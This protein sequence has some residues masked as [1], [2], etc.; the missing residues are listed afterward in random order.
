MQKKLK[1]YYKSTLKKYK[2][3]IAIPQRVFLVLAAGFGL[4]FVFL[5]PPFQEPDAPTHFLRAYQISDF[6]FVAEKFNDEKGGV[7]YGAP[8]PKS[9]VTATNELTGNIP[10]A[11]ANTFNKSLFKKYIAQPLN[12]DDTQMTVI[13]AAGVYSP[14][15]YIPQSIGIN[16][17][18]A[19]N[20]SPL[21]LVW[22]ARL[23]NLVLWIGVIYCAIRL[24][25]FAKWALVVF[26][27]SPIAVFFSA[28]LSPDVTNISLAFLFFSLIVSTLVTG[29]KV[30]GRKL[31]VILLVLFILALSKPVNLMFAFMLLLVPIR[32][33]GKTWKY[34]LYCGAGIVVSLALF[35]V[36]N[37]QVRELLEFQ[38]QIQSGGKNSVSGQLAYILHE[39]LTYIKDILR[40]YVIVANG[41]SG[42]A[43]LVTFFGVLGWLDT[44]VPLWTILLYVLTLF[45]ALLYQFGRGLVL[46]NRQKVFLVALFALAFVGNVTAMYLN[47]TAVGDSLIAGVQGRYFIPF[48][49]VL[50][51]LFTARKKILQIEERKIGAI[52]LASL[53]IVLIITAMKIAMRYYL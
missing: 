6:H 40:N 14:A 25:P 20:A 26:A 4:L 53:L 12:R 27:L 39:P 13:E 9:V 22:M 2:Q 5:T 8:I 36:W 43:V 16:I 52:I 50:I 35:Y 48:A 47:A 17:G 42:D 1:T 21:L 30:S 23:M 31:T 18:K 46:S 33:F 24:L 10:G 37:Q 41:T 29:A 45:F 51:G 32:H 11:P 15:V 19:F 28:S 7:H 3:S 34:L 38:V 44:S 49:V